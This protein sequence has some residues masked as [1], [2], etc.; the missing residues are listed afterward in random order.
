MNTITLTQD[1]VDALLKVGLKDLWY[2]ICPSGFVGERPVSLRRLGKKIALW[3]DAAGT[4][5]ALEDHCPHRGAPL[6]QGMVLGDRLACPYHGVEVRCDG[7]VTKVPG[8]PGCKLEG[9]R[10]AL[11]FHVQEAWGTIFLY[12]SDVNIDTPPPMT[13]PEEL[14]SPEYS[15][16]LCYAEWKGDYRYALDNVM[17][18]M[19]GTFLHK[20][21]HSM[22]EGDSTATFQI[23]TTDTGFVFEKTGQRGVNFDW[24]EWGST[25]VHW[26]RLEIPYPKTGGPGGN[27][28]IVACATP[29]DGNMTAV[30][31]WRCRKVSSWQRD[32][33]RF[34]YRNRLEAR[35]WAVLEQ[36]RIMLEQMEPDANQHENLY[37]HDIGVV[38]LRRHLRNLADEQLEAAAAAKAGAP[39]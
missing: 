8:S 22:A 2:P 7:T 33:W 16:F 36:D 3:R 34:L 15:H 38:R 10:A 30:F 5:H 37:Q 21:S 28:A 27:F 6:S 14:S 17:D 19:H 13:M 24:T 9:T 29:I 25:G 12:N 4:L 18:P 32:T 26:M 20:Q 35:H 11:S 31:F 1:P 39:A 23:R